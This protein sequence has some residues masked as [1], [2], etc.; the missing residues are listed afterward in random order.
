MRLREEEEVV[1]V[2]KSMK[3]SRL[4]NGQLENELE[5]LK[6]ENAGLVGINEEYLRELEEMRRWREGMVG[7]KRGWQE[8]VGMMKNTTA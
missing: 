8:K 7:E 2:E 5:Y 4:C 6:S 3:L 1:S